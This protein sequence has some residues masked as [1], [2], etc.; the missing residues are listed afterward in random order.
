V[1]LFSSTI[2]HSLLLSSKRSVGSTMMASNDNK[3]KYND[4]AHEEST[5]AIK[6]Q[7]VH[8]NDDNSSSS[9]AS[10]ETI[11]DVLCE[12]EEDFLDSEEKKL[13]QRWAWF[14][15]GNTS[16]PKHNSIGN[17]GI[18][19]SDDDDD[20]IDEFS[21]EDWWCVHHCVDTQ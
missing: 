10:E 11:D 18:G 16:K 1:V 14:D 7:H 17:V 15:D 12:P 21:D 5:A 20:P 9:S 19:Y 4:E 2:D 3:H 6:R 13:L 8:D